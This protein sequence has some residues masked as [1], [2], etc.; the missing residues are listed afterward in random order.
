NWTITSLM[1]SGQFDGDTA[2]VRLDIDDGWGVVSFLTTAG[3]LRF[4]CAPGFF[5]T[6]EEVKVDVRAIGLAGNASAPF[7][8]TIT[9]S[10]EAYEDRHGD[11][12][13]SDILIAIPL[14]GL[15]LFGWVI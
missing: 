8:T 15:F 6:S 2:L 9:I 7:T 4:L 12:H 14:Y 1:L 10:G 3:Q 13:D 11:R 5:V